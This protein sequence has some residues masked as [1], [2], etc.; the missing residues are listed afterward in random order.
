MS[1][2]TN[3]SCSH[4]NNFLHAHIAPVLSLTSSPEASLLLRLTRRNLNTTLSEN[5]SPARPSLDYSP[6]PVRL[7]SKPPSVSP[8][9]FGSFS[10]SSFGSQDSILLDNPALFAIENDSQLS[11]ISDVSPVIRALPSSSHKQHAP[12]TPFINKLM[13]A[14]QQ[15][16]SRN[17]DDNLLPVESGDSSLLS[18]CKL[19]PPIASSSRQPNEPMME[20]AQASTSTTQPIATSIYASK[21]GLSPSLSPLSSIASTPGS[22]IPPKAGPSK[23]KRFMSG[24]D[25]LP[26]TKRFRNF[27]KAAEA[28]LSE[29]SV[30]ATTPDTRTFPARIAISAS[31]PLFYRRFP[32]S[33]YIQLSAEYDS[34][35]VLFGVSHPGGTYNPPRDPFD[36]YTPRFVKGSG[37]SKVG[38]CPICIEPRERGGED[39]KIWLAMK[40]SAFNYHMQYAHGLS[41]RTGRPFS[42]P[43]SF[44]TVS[45]TKRDKKERNIIKEGKC[46]KCMKWF[47]VEGVKEAECKVPELFWWKHAAS[48][49]KGSTI[50]SETDIFR[51]DDVLKTLQSK[52]L[53]P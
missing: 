23:R 13:S 4:A 38:L 46:H 24:G 25:N 30:N 51:D 15:S 45:R 14:S 11:W 52:G 49:H 42:P 39:K 10:D 43:T 34:P 16:F 33:A 28:T 44:R 26:P 2:D 5:F 12:S 37:S 29:T 17:G 36:L 1:N 48:C 6:F 31:F 50:S 41:P 35:C 8:P 47:P 19:K 40:V 53:E 21:T 7:S 3:A 9:S 32:V 18:P 22:P 20:L 27:S